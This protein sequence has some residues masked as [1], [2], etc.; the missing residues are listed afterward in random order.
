MATLKNSVTADDHMEGS[1]DAPL[2]LVEYGDYQCP[3]C[4]MAYPIVKQVQKHF[5]RKLRFVFRNFPLTEAHPLAES[6]AETAEFAGAHGKFWDA[7]D[8]LY[9]NQ[10]RLGP[11]FYEALAKKLGFSA[12]SLGE[13]LRNGTYRARIR[14][15]FTGGVR[16]GVNGT[17]A[18]YINGERH[19]ASYDYDSLVAALES[20]L[21]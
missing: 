8:L 10:E 12:A 20:A 15:D 9:E 5:G 4:G 21:G 11:E 6:A 2:T 16:S 3:Y 7:H 17:P 19:D 18:F 13:A 14:A 1:A